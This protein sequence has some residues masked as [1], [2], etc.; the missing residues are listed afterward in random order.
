[1]ASLHGG[2]VWWYAF[3]TVAAFVGSIPWLSCAE[4]LVHR[5]LM[6]RKFV[7][8]FAWEL[9]S[10]HHKIFGSDYTYHALD[11]E[12]ARHITFDPRDYILL[13]LA[14]LPIYCAVEFLIH[15]PIVVGCV[16]ATLAYLHSFQVL[17]LAWHSPAD[18]F[19]EEHRWFLWMK[20]RHR[21]HHADTS[22]RYNLIVPIVD[23]TLIAI[24]ALRSK[25]SA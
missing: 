13:T 19:Y 7:P 23:G 12:M 18:R 10:Q 3:W 17:H 16:L 21:L 9:H 24:K 6:H 2:S 25:K 20:E 5:F 14:N 1:M 8:K 11:D 15:R 4:Y 22:S